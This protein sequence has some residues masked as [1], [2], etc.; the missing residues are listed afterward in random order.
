VRLCDG[1]YYALS[2][3]SQPHSFLNDERR[4]RSSCS[5]PTKLF[6]SLNPDDDSEQMV[7]LT[8]ERYGELPNAF[9][10][11]TEYV[12]ACNASRS[13]GAPKPKPRMTAAPSS[14]REPRASA[15]LPQAPERWRRSWR[16]P[17]PGS[18]KAGPA[19]GMPRSG[20]ASPPS[21][22]RSSGPDIALFASAVACSHSRHRQQTSR[23]HRA[24]SSCSAIARP[25]RLAVPA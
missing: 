21:T 18:R 7:A 10:Y 15:L 8:G 23:R 16:I 25:V 4:C 11:R 9:R 3:A 24:A 13:H 6:Y 17:T 14:Q 12:D 22:G 2:E 20:S 19:P 5:S 1:F